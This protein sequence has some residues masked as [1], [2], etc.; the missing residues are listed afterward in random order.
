MKAW[1]LEC[2]NCGPGLDECHRVLVS[3]SVCPAVECP[4]CR[5]KMSLTE[6]VDGVTTG[7]T[8]GVC[9]YHRCG[10]AF[11]KKASHQRFCSTTH[12][13]YDWQ[14]KHFRKLAEEGE[15]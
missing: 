1:V 8:H 3:A 2:H 4:R 12:R 9:E 13:V 14:E 5:G 15:K 11:E 7:I 10:K 6:G